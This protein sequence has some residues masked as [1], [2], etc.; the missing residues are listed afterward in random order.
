M[1]SSA[2]VFDAVNKFCKKF[3]PRNLSDLYIRIPIA[4]Y[5]MNEEL[6]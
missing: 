2:I 4:D 1:Y 3:P 6:K 5:K